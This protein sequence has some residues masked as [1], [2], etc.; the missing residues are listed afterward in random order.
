MKRISL[1]EVKNLP[2]GTNVYVECVGPNWHLPE[3]E[4]K[5]WNIKKEDGL[6]YPDGSEISF[7]YNFDYIAENMEIACYVGTYGCECCLGDKELYWKDH[8]N[9]A[10]VDSKGNVLVTVDGKGLTFIVNYCPACGKKFDK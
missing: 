1:E 5:S 6:Y 4:M 2:D 9:N 7:Q 10:F 8:N 3:N